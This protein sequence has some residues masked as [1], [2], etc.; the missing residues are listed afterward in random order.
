MMLSMSRLWLVL[1]GAA[2]AALVFG[3]L[4]W[5]IHA[6]ADSAR[7]E[8]NI[9]WRGE[10]AKVNEQVALAKLVHEQN[11]ARL[12][13]EARTKAN[14]FQRQFDELEHANAALPDNSCG[15]EH[16]RVRLLRKE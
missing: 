16:D 15:I 4:V 9:Y 8:R 10:I 13:D 12:Q 6:V 1:G 7:E 14:D 11:V 3:A 2:A 5:L